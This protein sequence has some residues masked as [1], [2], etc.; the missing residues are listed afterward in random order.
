VA[1]APDGKTL[2]TAGRDGTARL[3]NLATGQEMRALK[4]CEYDAGRVFS[5]AFS[6]DGKSLVSGG[7]DWTVRRWEVATGK[8]V[9]AYETKHGQVFSL[10]LSRDAKWLVTGGAN[11]KVA[12]NGGGAELWD[13]FAGGTPADAHKQE[14]QKK[15]QGRASERTFCDDDPVHSTVLSHDG[16]LLV[17]GSQ[18]DPARLWEVSTGKQIRVF[19]RD[20]GWGHAVTLTADGKQLIT[21][22]SDGTTRFWELATGKELCSLASFRDGTWAVFDADGRF[23]SANNGDVKGMHWVVGMQT[24]PLSRFKDRFYDPGLLAK[25]LGHNEQP[26]RKLEAIPD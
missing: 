23:D 7:V 19:P 16:K 24:F 2:A 26:L 21:A 1:L 10:Y 5:I 3:W 8:Q 11:A 22:S 14:K 15:A 17:T 9:R 25:Y 20:S 12:G 6:S 4:H 18:Y 13:V